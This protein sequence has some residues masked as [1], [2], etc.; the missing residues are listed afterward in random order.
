MATYPTLDNIMARA[1]ARLD[2]NDWNKEEFYDNLEGDE[3]LVV[4]YVIM[5]NQVGN[6]G[7][8]QWHH[9]GYIN[10]FGLNRIRRTLKLID[11]D[12]S[13]EVLRILDEFM[14]LLS[15]FGVDPNDPNSYV[16]EHDE[17]E[18]YDRADELDDAFYRVNEKVLEQLEAIMAER[19]KA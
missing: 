6:G 9:N 19:A 15:D 7:W 16:D 18:F 17:E 3:D 5:N 12:E 11:S 4:P 13:R 1:Y 2:E 14:K 8:D 10:D